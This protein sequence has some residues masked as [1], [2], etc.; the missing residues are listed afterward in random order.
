M[1]RGSVGLFPSHRPA[2]LGHLQHVCRRDE[3]LGFRP[4]APTCRLGS[5]LVS[6][7]PD[8][9]KKQTCHPQQPL[10]LDTPLLFLVPRHEA[11]S[12]PRLHMRGDNHT[13]S[14]HSRMVS[15]EPVHVSSVLHFISAATWIQT[16]SR[17]GRTARGHRKHG[18]VS[19][20]SYLRM[21]LPLKAP[22]RWRRARDHFLAHRRL[23][24]CP[25]SPSQP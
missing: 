4:C 20:F 17:C 15:C 13:P 18:Y 14:R 1:K 25:P 9:S 7:G 8:R 5:F 6:I 24:R 23:L 10:D 22:G 2:Y 21:S 3:P 16:L 19:I 11:C 12:P